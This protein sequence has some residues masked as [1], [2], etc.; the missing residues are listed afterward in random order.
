VSEEEEEEESLNSSLPLVEE[1]QRE[2]KQ[3]KTK[4]RK[5]S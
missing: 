4:E 1:S 3:S 5:P 2:A